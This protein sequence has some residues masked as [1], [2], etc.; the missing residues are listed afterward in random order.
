ME[1]SLDYEQ[2]GERIK[3]QRLSLKLTQEKLAEA[4]G[5][6][7]QHLSKIE[8]GKA[9]LSLALLVQLA[10]K[11]Q[12]TTDYLLMGNVEAVTPHLLAEAGELLTDC[13]PAELYVLMKTI[14]AVKKSIRH[15]GLHT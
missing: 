15:K 14:E 2:I 8:N 7:I 6:G 3:K 9:K 10:N 13:S 5:V 1:Y 4:V 12:T 11:M